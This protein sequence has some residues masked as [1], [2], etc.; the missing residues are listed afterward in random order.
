[1]V[2]V[3][4]IDLFIGISQKLIESNPGKYIFYIIGDG[5]LKD[6]CDDIILKNNLEHDVIALG[7]IENPLPILKNMDYLIITSDHEGLPLNLLEAMCL[8]VPVISNNV[9]GVTKALGNGKYGYL[10]DK[11]DPN[12]YA[13][14]IIDNDKNQIDVKEK[15]ELAFANVKRNYSSTQCADSY[16]DL[17][18]SICT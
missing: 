15:V 5:P 3:K 10:V 2:P 14:I 9:G 11:Q 12:K 16:N 18:Y 1:M 17:Y 6:N 4:R 13:N 8:K 7:F